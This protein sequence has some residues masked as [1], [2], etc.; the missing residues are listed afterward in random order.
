MDSKRDVTRAVSLRRSAARE[1][2]RQA[3]AAG[4]GQ[5][6]QFVP[7]YVNRL[8]I[9]CYNYSATIE[10]IVPLIWRIHSRTSTYRDVNFLC[11]CQEAF[12][13]IFL[14]LQKV[15]NVILCCYNVNHLSPLHR[16]HKKL[17]YSMARF[18]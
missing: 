17:P 13:L 8:L 14:L 3:A 1:P 7:R 2:R 5:L 6:P 16:A 4:G 10:L 18:T 12:V 9:C 15:T 11:S